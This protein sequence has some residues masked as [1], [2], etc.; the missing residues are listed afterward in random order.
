[1]AHPRELGGFR[2]APVTQLLTYLTLGGT[3][4]SGVI[5][6]LPAALSLARPSQLPQ[7]WRLLTSSLLLCDDLGAALVAAYLLYRLRLFERQMGSSKF[8]AFVC[9]G[10]AADGLARLAFVALPALG[11]GGGVASG[12]FQV[13]M[14]LLPLYFR[15]WRR[16][17]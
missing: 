9:L 5:P 2:G 15:A 4:L 1:M 7:A 3:L 14:G 16:D 10:T 13:V 6:R 12:P 11:G 8:A 17:W